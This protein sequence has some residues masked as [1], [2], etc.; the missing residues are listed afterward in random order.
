MDFIRVAWLRSRGKEQ[1]I[2]VANSM[3]GRELAEGHEP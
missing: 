2:I 1:A 3:P